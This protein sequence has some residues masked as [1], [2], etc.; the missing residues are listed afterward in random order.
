MF[1]ALSTARQIARRDDDKNIACFQT[2]WRTAVCDNPS[3]LFIQH[4]SGIFRVPKC[5]KIGAFLK[6]AFA[7]HKAPGVCW[8]SAPDD[9]V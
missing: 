9:R 3:I 8:F 5:V 2:R 1:S 7:I 6:A 4:I